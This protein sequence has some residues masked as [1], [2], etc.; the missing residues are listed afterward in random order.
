MPR[1]HRQS[2]S[3]TCGTSPFSNHTSS[4]RHQSPC[5]V[6][7]LPPAGERHAHAASS[8]VPGAL[9]AWTVNGSSRPA[10]RAYRAPAGSEWAPEYS[11]NGML[12]RRPPRPPPSADQPPGQYRQR[13]RFRKNSPPA[14]HGI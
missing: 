7:N 5:G 14:A 4:H 3:E 12:Q 13:V 9:L 6:A 10:G 11:R 2:R 8:A 1:N